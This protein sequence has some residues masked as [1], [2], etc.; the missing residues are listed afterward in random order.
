MAIVVEWSKQAA[1][2]LE[3]VFGYHK[4]VAG[5]G[6]A[7]KIVTKISRHT[8]ILADNPYAGPREEVL[9]DLEVEFRYLVEGNYKILYYTRPEKIVVSLVFDCRQNPE[10]MRDIK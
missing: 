6:V 2:S 1:S 10:K 8:R 9:K 7:R 4:K 3:E 5:L